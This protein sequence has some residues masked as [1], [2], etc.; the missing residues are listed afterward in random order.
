MNVNLDNVDL[1]FVVN[2]RTLREVLAGLSENGRTWWIASD[3][4]D[5]LERG[6]VTIGHGDPGCVDRL[7]TLYYRVPVLNE[8]QPL[9]GSDRT[10]VLLDAGVV[11]AEQ[12]G[13]YLERG[14]VLEDVIEDIESF[15]LPIQMVLARR[16]RR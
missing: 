8:E 1:G 7:N 12:P 10:V 13:L 9:G 2:I 5:A 16:F 14:R 6:Y 4:A 11:S 15:F 3:P